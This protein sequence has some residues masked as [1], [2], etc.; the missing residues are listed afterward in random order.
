VFL[1]F[2]LFRNVSSGFALSFKE[3]LYF[4]S[5]GNVCGLRIIFVASDPVLAVVWL[6]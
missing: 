2:F 1:C 6:L 5:S 4:V 3:N